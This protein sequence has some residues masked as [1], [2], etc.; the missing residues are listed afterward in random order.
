ME[1]IFVDRLLEELRRELRRHA[2]KEHAAVAQRFFKTGAGEYGEGD[3]FLGVRVP[4]IRRLVKTCPETQASD[5]KPLLQSPFHEERMLALLILVRNYAEGDGRAKREIFDIY[6]KNRKFIN[7]WDLVD[8][9]AEH[10]VGA[11]LEKKSKKPLYQLAKSKV[12]WDRRIA[13]LATFRY[14][15][16][17]SLLETLKIAEMLIHDHEDLIHK[18]VGWMLREL[19]KRDLAEEEVF[20]KSRYKTMPRTM[21]R[22]AIEAFPESKRQAYLKEI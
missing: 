15:K 14:I 21:L 18:A 20:L 11:F 22:Y 6:W 9:S 10:V 8:A 3:L 17:Y 12:L 4:A 2:N 19:G 5:L 16:K 1:Q 13:I 7:N